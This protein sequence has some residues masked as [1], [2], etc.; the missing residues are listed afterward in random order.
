MG[1]INLLLFDSICKY[2]SCNKQNVSRNTR[3]MSRFHN[4]LCRWED[5]ERESGLQLVHKCGSVQVARKE[6]G[7]I[8]SL[9]KYAKA[10]DQYSIPCVS[11]DFV[12]ID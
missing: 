12:Y 4:L 3:N 9:E 10:L 6:T 7:G 11:S 1:A 5:V 2:Q 8:E